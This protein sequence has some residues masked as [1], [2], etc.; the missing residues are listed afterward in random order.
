MLA[1]ALSLGFIISW[2]WLTFLNGPVLS[3]F[4]AGISEKPEYVFLSYL[5]LHSL[6]Y[7]AL[8]LVAMKYDLN[9]CKNI[10]MTSSALAVA[11]ATCTAFIASKSMMI[12][13]LALIAA[14]IGSAMLLG[15]CGLA[16]SRL[17]PSEA[18]PAFGGA[19][20]LGTLLLWAGGIL[21]VQFIIL[22]TAVCPLLSLTLLYKCQNTVAFRKET[23]DG[24]KNVTRLLPRRLVLLILAFYS[25]GGF[26]YKLL[27]TA[28]YAPQQEMYQLTNLVYCGVTV[29]AGGLIYCFRDLDLRLLYRPV[30]PLLGVSF[31]LFSVVPAVAHIIPLVLYQAGFA[32]FDAYTWLLF[33]Y[34]AGMLKK[35]L[36]MIGWGMFVLTFS[37]FTGD[38]LLTMC[39]PYFIPTL[40]NIQAISV[41]AAILMLVSSL[42]FQ[43]RRETFAGWDTDIQASPAAKPLLSLSPPEPP[44]LPGPEA[45]LACY[46][47]T[48]REKEIS[49]LLLKGRNNPYIRNTLNISENTLKTHLRNI[50]GKL[51]VSDRQEL[52]SRYEEYQ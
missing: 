28:N 39:L 18:A 7:L 45:F 38:F 13:Y 27:Y 5:L 25:V 6:S 52:V 24:A 41:F 51:L 37:I 16:F 50:Y 43:D 40:P 11:I 17:A 46:E 42:L 4:S 31:M 12:S 15:N 9:P 8:A 3:L 1:H 29:L 48:P 14:A 44:P 47:L 23:N 19:V 49:L 26:M 32:L 22:P 21:P 20:F 10:I 35:P 2:L 36:T 33:A 30:L 34:L